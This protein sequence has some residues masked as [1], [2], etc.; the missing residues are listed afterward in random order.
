VIPWASPQ[1]QFRAHEAAIRDAIDRVLKSNAYVLGPEVAGFERAFA[2]YLGTAHAV[3]VASGT[4]SLILA[5]RGMDIGPGDEV[6]TV[7]HTAVAT[8]SAILASG[9]QPVLVDVEPDFYTIDTARI[10]EAITPRTRAIIA[11]HLYGQAANLDAILPIAKKHGLKLIEDCAQATGARHRGRRVGSIGDAGCFSFYPTKNLG[12]I[13]DG[14]AVATQDAE[15][16]ARIRRLAQYG[17]DEHR[18]TRGTGINSRLDPLQAAIL[19]A[20]LPHL[21][22]DNARRAAIAAR[23]DAGLAGLKLVVPAKRSDSQHVFHLYVIAT[24]NRDALMASLA[25]GGI[26]SALHYFPAVHRQECYAER[27]KLPQD[28]LPVTTRLSERIVSLPMY[29]EISDADTDTVIAAVRAAFGT[30]RSVVTQ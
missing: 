10:V 5:L 12:G 29:P 18:K 22:A 28:G 2:D 20:K 30:E 13:G 27:V 4:D 1:A 17:W 3:G 11:V 21:D 14:G 9:A 19:A 8:V 15:L 26:G 6:I 24:D 25:K 7:A 23:Y 16:A